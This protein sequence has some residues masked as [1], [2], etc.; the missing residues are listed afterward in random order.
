[1]GPEGSKFVSTTQQEL[2]ASASYLTPCQRLHPLMWISHHWPSFRRIPTS[3]RPVKL[4]SL[5]SRRLVI[6]L[7]TPVINRPFHCRHSFS[8]NFCTEQHFYSFYSAN[9]LNYKEKPK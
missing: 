4:T 8:I 1:M 3:L 2:M 9:V 7:N 5:C 6:V